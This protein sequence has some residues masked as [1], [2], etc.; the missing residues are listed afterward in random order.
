MDV[1][2]TKDTYEREEDEAERLVR[3]AP[4]LK[5][6]RHDKKRETVHEQDSDTDGDA[7]LK[8]DP[9]LSLNYKSVGGSL[10]ERIAEKWIRVK[11]KELDKGTRVRPETLQKEPGKYENCL[12]YTSDAADE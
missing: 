8:G 5:P 10:V 6:P 4:K 3:P 9:D 7:D 11:N 2:A 1:R 12:L